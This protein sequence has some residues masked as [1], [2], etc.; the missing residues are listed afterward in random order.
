MT[1]DLAVLGYKMLIGLIIIGLFVYMVVTGKV[2]PTTALTV[3]LP[4]LGSLLLV[5]G[6]VSIAKSRTPPPRD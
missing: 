5:D 2:G 1:I 3:I 6:A 4:M